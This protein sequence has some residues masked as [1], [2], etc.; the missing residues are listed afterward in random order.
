MKGV[1]VA[2]WAAGS[3]NT[4]LNLFKW[5]EKQAFLHLTQQQTMRYSNSSLRL[6]LLFG[7]QHKYA[8]LRCGKYGAVKRCC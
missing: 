2:Y 4:G 6:E 7:Q 3:A 5:S 8:P 1:V